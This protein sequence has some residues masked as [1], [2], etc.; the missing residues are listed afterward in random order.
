[1]LFI[2][3]PGRPQAMP[4]RRYFRSIGAEPLSADMKRIDVPDISGCQ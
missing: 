2:S 1:M 4:Q 3:P